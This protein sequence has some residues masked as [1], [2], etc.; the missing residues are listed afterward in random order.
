MTTLKL[1]G[2]VFAVFITSWIVFFFM[3]S[4]MSNQNTVDNSGIVW[5]SVILAGIGAVITLLAAVSEIKGNLE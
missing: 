4:A 5:G 2:L 3:L 1:I